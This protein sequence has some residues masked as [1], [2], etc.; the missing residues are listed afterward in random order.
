MKKTTEILTRFGI[1]DIILNNREFG[2]SGK[3]L[4]LCNNE[5]KIIRQVEVYFVGYEDEDGNECE[6]DGTY[7][8]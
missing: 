8:D 5:G 3:Y 1:S 7:L 6:E 4:N 2:Y